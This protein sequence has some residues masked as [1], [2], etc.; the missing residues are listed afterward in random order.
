MVVDTIGNTVN[1]K[2]TVIRTAVDVS[3]ALDDARSPPPRL[4]RRHRW[5]HHT[6]PMNATTNAGMTVTA[7]NKSWKLLS[8]MQPIGSS[9]KSRETKPKWLQNLMKAT[10][11]CMGYCVTIFERICTKVTRICPNQDVKIFWSRATENGKS[12][13]VFHEKLLI[14]GFQTFLIKISFPGSF[15]PPF[16]PYDHGYYTHEQ[17]KKHH[18]HCI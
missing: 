1:R 10:G 5:T 7:T 2:I 13:L 4:N 9:D 18:K 12:N 14:K 16:E 8:T 11:N 3:L 15:S 6:M 17:H